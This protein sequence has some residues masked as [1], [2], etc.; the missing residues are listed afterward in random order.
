MYFHMT[1]LINNIN[2]T[3]YGNRARKYAAF[4]ELLTPLATIKNTITHDAIKHRV[5]SQ[6][7]VPEKKNNILEEF[8]FSPASPVES[9]Y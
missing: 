5:R 1:Y 3:T 7:G 2:I 6:R 8:Y 9:H 4:P